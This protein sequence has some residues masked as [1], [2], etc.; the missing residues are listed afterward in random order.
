MLADV[1]L[2][3]LAYVAGVHRLIVAAVAGLS[4]TGCGSRAATTVPPVDTG[5]F[6][7]ALARLHAAGLRVGAEGFGRMPAGYRLADAFVG[8]QDPEAG[9]RVPRGSVVRLNMHGANPIPSPA[10]P[11]HRPRF[12]VVP[13]LVGLPEPVAEQRLGGGFWPEL[14]RIAP[15]PASKSGRGLYA[16]VVTSQSPRPGTRMPYFGRTVAGGGF[17][18]SVVRLTLAV[19]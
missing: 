12:A 4:L 7:T 13:S 8:D 5:S 15:L 14:T 2:D 19:R 1:L 17:R 11:K 18:V 3:T 10:V 16:Y 9:T 6:G